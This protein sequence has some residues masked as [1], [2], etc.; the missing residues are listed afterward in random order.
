M[1]MEEC[2]T[3]MGANYHRVLR[4]LGKESLLVKIAEMFPQDER[5]NRM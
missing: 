2:Y 1:T 4:R 5:Y 3:Q